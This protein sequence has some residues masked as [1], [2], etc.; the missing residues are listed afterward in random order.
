MIGGFDGWRPVS[1]YGAIFHFRWRDS[2]TKPRIA[3]LQWRDSTSVQNP[4][5]PPAHAVLKHLLLLLLSPAGLAGAAH[6]RAAAGHGGGGA[7]VAEDGA[8]QAAEHGTAHGAFGGVTAGA[9]LVGGGLAVRQV[10]LVLRLVGL[11]RTTV[12]L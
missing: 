5:T 11:G 2:G 8:E 9:D 1:S 10:L 4:I 6:H 7:G 3:P 12:T